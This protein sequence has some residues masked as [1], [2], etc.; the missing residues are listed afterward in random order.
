MVPLRTK[1][2]PWRCVSLSVLVLVSAAARPAEGQVLLEGGEVSTVLD[3]NQLTCGMANDGSVCRIISTVSSSAS[4]HWPDGTLNQHSYSS[5]FQLAGMI[6]H[7]EGL[8]WSGDTI[9]FFGFNASGPGEARP[10]T[11]M[12]V[13]RDW[14]GEPNTEALANWPAEGDIPEFPWLSAHITDDEL[15]H[16][17]LLGRKVASQEDS[18]VVYWDGED[19]LTDHE[20]DQHPAGLLVE[21]RTLAWDYPYG[22]DGTIYVVLR[23]RNISDN[24]Y[25][26]QRMEDAFFEGED[27]L[28]D[29]GWTLRN[30]YLAYA[31]DPDVTNDARANFGVP[32][33]PFDLAVTYAS[34]FTAPEFQYP[35]W[36][37][38]PPFFE[39]AT[40]LWGTVLLRTPADDPQPVRRMFS[41]YTGGG[42]FS[43]PAGDS[44]LLRVLSGDV[45]PELGDGFCNVSNHR[46][47]GICF[48]L[49]N[50]AD[51]RQ[52]QSTGP[53]SLAPG[54]SFTLVLAMFAAPPVNVPE[55]VPGSVNPSVLTQDEPSWHP[56]CF[57]A[58][59]TPI[60][61]A[62]GWV[63]TEDCPAAEGERLDPR[64]VEVLDASLLHKARIARELVDAGFLLPQPPEPPEFQ[65]SPGADGVLVTWQ[66]S[67]TED[68]GDPFY[69]LAGDPDA[70]L[71]DPNYRQ[72]DVEGYRVYRSTD[73][74]NYEQIAQFDYAHTRFVDRTCATRGDV[75]IGEPCTE[76]YIEP[77]TRRLV[78]YP[79]N[80]R[81]R[82]NDAW[83]QVFETDTAPGE[84]VDDGVPFVFEDT[85]ARP[86]FEYHYRV[87]A[88]DV[89]SV[90]SGP[91]SLESGS[92]RAKTIIAQPMAAGVVGADSV[93]AQVQVLL[94]DGTGAD[95]TDEQSI[96]SNGRFSGPP[97]P[98]DAF[99]GAFD[100]IAPQVL[101]EGETV[102]V[103]TLDSVVPLY[104][105][106]AYYFSGADG[107][108][109][110]LGSDQPSGLA[111]YVQAAGDS[112]FLDQTRPV[113]VAADPAL[114]DSIMQAGGADP[115]TVGGHARAELRW[116]LPH[117]HSGDADWAYVVCGFWEICPPED[118]LAGGSRW[119]A[120]EN[121]S[122]EHPTL[123]T[124]HGRL[125]GVDSIFQPLPYQGYGGASPTFYEGHH[126]DLIRRFY[127]TTWSAR[128]VADIEIRW[129]AA[130]GPPE[131]FDVTHRVPVPFR[132]AVRASW[133]FRNDADGDGVITWGDFF[134][135]PGFDHSGVN[136]R[137][138]SG[139]GPDPE[140]E[141][142]PVLTEVDVDGDL[143]GDGALG[144]GLYIAGEPYIFRTASIPTNTTWTLRTHSG[145]V[146]APFWGA[147]YV[148]VDDG[149]MRTPGV[150]GLR[151]AVTVESARSYFPDLVDLDDVRVVPDPFYG[152]SAFDV[153]PTDARI[154]FMNLPPRASIR[155]YSVSGVLVDVVN[156][157]GGTGGLTSWDLRSRE[158]E[159]VAS[160]V[161][162][163][164]I[165]TPEGR[166]HTGR[167][168]IVSTGLGE[169]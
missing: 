8:P 134:R 111:R 101:A 151:L 65:V 37:F 83:V 40:S 78:Q 141:R 119:F 79:P 46:E 52:F 139:A 129:G 70:A 76:E 9:G 41:N 149:V 84:L 147:E 122:M 22:N 130:G 127:Q 162:F 157:D 90:R 117:W 115:P 62:A 28:P 143:L 74:E 48:I 4:G 125:P 13:S 30:V 136:W 11:N 121:E 93:R 26:Q 85:G 109:Y 19:W 167:F 100:A 138:L 159:P 88:F 131:V 10:I 34:T 89:N 42:A 51:V 148:H 145:V 92:L 144:F 142:T 21:Q 155:I 2:L 15:Y 137:E 154:R 81:V 150:P 97:P 1:P 164:H 105:S 5:G 116:A 43:D 124:A 166:E 60:E 104:Y 106:G 161:Y 23:V 160:G 80:G 20:P 123:G 110:V 57:G 135:T 87:T 73:G 113:A 146:T 32:S 107:R 94:G 82:M 86:G 31:A 120:G 44:Q 67:A 50:Q 153:S 24:V 64:N 98:T 165:A 36:F 156:H 7:A 77:I 39:S 27:A 18:W 35:P 53:Y 29:S 47:R 96:D 55:I 128:R 6:T 61:R 33:L 163:Y 72:F 112:L 152:E 58:E 126:N 56:G 63:A 103:M 3:V 14:S 49:P 133:G 118:A 69:G 38:H 59:I 16:P 54:E 68:T 132:S 91:A 99:S 158:G 45:R 71:H 75:A 17:L 12:W 108:S 66:P 168:T 102:A 95:P 169:Q 140:L 114:R 25:F